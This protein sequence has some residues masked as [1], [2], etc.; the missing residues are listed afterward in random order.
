[1]VTNSQLDPSV[2]GYKP[3][4]QP[5][6]RCKTRLKKKAT[7]RENWYRGCNN[8]DKHNVK[9]FK[10]AGNY[11]SKKAV[12]QLQASTVMFLPKTK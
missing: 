1:M 2:Q 11:N 4:D 10:K 6:G 8:K 3:L 12:Q 5:S 9:R 7:A